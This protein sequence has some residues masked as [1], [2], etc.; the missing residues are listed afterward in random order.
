[1]MAGTFFTKL[2]VGNFSPPRSGVNTAHALVDGP[3]ECDPVPGRHVGRRLLLGRELLVAEQTL[4]LRVGEAHHLAHPRAELP[5]AGG[6]PPDSPS[7][8]TTFQ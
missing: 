3:R 5:R 2:S 8:R 6:L 1:M 7:Q 4:E